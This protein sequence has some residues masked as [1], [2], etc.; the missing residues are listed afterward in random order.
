MPPSS[1]STD[2]AM[3]QLQQRA[4]ELIAPLI[5]SDARERI[6]RTVKQW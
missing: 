4:I 5:P 1:G 6:E 3:D 2:F